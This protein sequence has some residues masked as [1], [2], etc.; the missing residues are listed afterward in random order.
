[1]RADYKLCP[2]FRL[3]NWPVPTTPA[4]FESLLQSIDY[5]FFFLQRFIYKIYKITKI[6]LRDKE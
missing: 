5:Y 2:N 1:M 6:Y 3:C 4:L